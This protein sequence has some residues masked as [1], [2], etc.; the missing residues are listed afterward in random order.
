[1]ERDGAVFLSKI[2]RMGLPEKMELLSI[3]LRSR[4]CY[5]AIWGRA[6]QADGIASAKALRWSVVACLGHPE[7]ERR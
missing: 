4:R 1:M 7:E 3:D 6:F 2:V 5:L